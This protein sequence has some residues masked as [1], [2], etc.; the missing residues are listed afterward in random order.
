[1]PPEI[2]SSSK[3]EQTR[4]LALKLE[5]QPTNMLA[6]ED[7]SSAEKPASKGNSPFDV[8]NLLNGFGKT[9][10]GAMGEA[11]S[12][13]PTAESLLPVEP[14][15]EQKP[16]VS[17]QKPSVSEQKPS[18]SEQKPALRSDA[19]V[20]ADRVIK[21]I[22]DSTDP[23]GELSTA[24]KNMDNLRQ[25]DVSRRPDG[26]HQVNLSFEHAGMAPPIK[27]NIRG[28]RPGATRINEDVSFVL[29]HSQNGGIKLEAMR[30][31]S[32]SVTG[33]LGRVRPSWT[34]GMHIGKDNRGVAFV[35]V[36]STVQGPL[37]MRGSSNRFYE[38][39]FPAGSPIKQIMHNPDLLNEV[40]GALRLFQKTDD[41]NQITIKKIGEGKFDVVTHATDAKDIPLNQ[42][43]EK[44]GV[45]VSSLTLSKTLSAS[46]CRDSKGVCLSNIQ[47]LKVNLESE[48]LG[49]TAIVPRKVGLTTNDKG[50]P[51]VHIEIE[52]PLLKGQIMP[53]DI[54]VSKLQE[55]RR[56]K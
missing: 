53:F 41:L 5:G 43:L 35:D 20:I 15:A 22:G 29:S 27:A 33:P 12:W 7:E 6:T 55:L 13:L 26:K 44:F 36:D 4:P 2:D 19:G 39:N 30:G 25:A 38:N 54:P 51:I 28:F 21:R 9:I 46:L 45:T 14:V 16:V 48:G 24:L 3:P 31:F 23:V 56:N 40:G 32:G 52:H 42:K 10:K 18:V 17:E 37:R 1:M 34:N 47:G 11:S 8:P 49:K 50:V